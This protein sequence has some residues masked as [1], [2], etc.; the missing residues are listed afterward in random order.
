MTEHATRQGG[1][2]QKPGGLVSADQ[3]TILGD[4]T[5]D[6]PLRVAAGL[7]AAHVRLMGTDADFLA[8][9]GFAGI[10]RMGVGVYELELLVAAP[11]VTGIVPTCTA[12]AALLGTVVASGLNET[13]IQVNRFNSA[14]APVDASFY[15]HVDIVP[16]V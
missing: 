16:V 13:T 15:I 9:S 5:A 4:G 12:V 1:A 11:D 14:G 2:I 8:Q 10:T 6:N 3:T 7:I